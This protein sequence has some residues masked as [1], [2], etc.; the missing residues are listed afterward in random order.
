MNTSKTFSLKKAIAVALVAAMPLGLAACDDE[1][2][3]GLESDEEVGQVE[4]GVDDAADEAE[5]QVDEG[6]EEGGEG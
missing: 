3:D 6:A 5:E 4:E 1:D 2:N